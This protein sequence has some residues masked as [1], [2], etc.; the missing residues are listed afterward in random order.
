[1]AEFQAANF[2]LRLTETVER[3]V[4]TYAGRRNLD[5][6]R[7][8]RTLLRHLRLESPDYNI[9]I[10]EKGLGFYTS[11]VDNIF[12]K[13]IEMQ[14]LFSK[15][16]FE[17]LLF[18]SGTISILHGVEDGR[19]WGCIGNIDFNRMSICPA[20]RANVMIFNEP[21]IARNYDLRPIDR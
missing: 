18:K 4:T 17:I 8:I 14:D 7:I 13:D 6:K 3:F 10:Y 11:L 21:D 1:M 2:V 12:K 15:F 16:K 5:R 20:T 9:V 19:K